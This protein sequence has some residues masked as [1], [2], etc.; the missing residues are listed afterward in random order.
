MNSNA[1]RSRVPPSG[2]DRNAVT[3]ADAAFISFC[4]VIGGA[5]FTYCL[6]LIGA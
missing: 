1:K 5:L 6:A 3:R 2:A 4:A